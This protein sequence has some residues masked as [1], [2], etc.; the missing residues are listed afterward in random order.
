[1][2]LIKYNMQ[3]TILSQKLLNLVIRGRYYLKDV[4]IWKRRLKKNKD[5]ENIHNGETCYILGNGPS[6]SDVKLDMLKGRHIITVNLSVNT[7]LFDEVQPEYHIITDRERLAEAKAG[8]D[9]AIAQG[10]ETKYILHR[11]AYEL[12]GKQEHI[13]YSYAT[14]MPTSRKLKKQMTGNTNGFLNV[15]PYASLCA[16]YMG[17]KRIVLLGNDFS[18][19][20]ARHDLHYYDVKEKIERRESLYQDLSGC[21]MVLLYYRYLYKYA[22]EHGVELLN[23][24]EGSL[25]DEIPIVKIEDVL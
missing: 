6:L 21:S 11:A 18:F 5:L 19:F 14:L 4:W 24:T 17:F 10:K 23:A 25:L 1:M 8:I 15:L 20:T 13:Y 16:M 9:K 12:F 2:N 7:P 22:Q 3:V